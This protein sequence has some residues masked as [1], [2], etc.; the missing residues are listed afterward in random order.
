MLALDYVRSHL[1]E[2]RLATLST[3]LCL[4][5]EKR[6]QGIPTGEIVMEGEDPSGI[7]SSIQELNDPILG[8]LGI[9]IGDGNLDGVKDLPDYRYLMAWLPALLAFEY[10]LVSDC[11]VRHGAVRPL[12]AGAM[13]A[14]QAVAVICWRADRHGG[15]QRY[16]SFGV[17]GPDA[18]DIPDGR[19]IVGKVTASSPVELIRLD[20]NDDVYHQ[21]VVAAN[22]WRWCQPH[23]LVD[24]EGL[25]GVLC[26]YYSGLPKGV[27]GRNSV[28]RDTEATFLCRAT[29]T[30]ILRAESA[31]AEMSMWKRTL[32]ERANRLSV[33][34][35][36]LGLAHD[37]SARTARL[38]VVANALIDALPDQDIPEAKQQMRSQLLKMGLSPQR[39]D[40][41]ES[42]LRQV[43]ADSTFLGE[44]IEVVNK[45]SKSGTVRRGKNPLHE[46]IVGA[47]PL[48]EAI[49][50]RTCQLEYELRGR[51]VVRA[52]DNDIARLLLNLVGNAI[53]WHATKITVSTS[54][55]RTTG[56]VRLS[57]QDNGSGMSDE[58]RRNCLEPFATDRQGGTG[59]GL[60][61]VDHLSRELGGM[62]KI[63]STLGVGTTVSIDL[64]DLA[65]RK[66]TQ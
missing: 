17:A 40:S 4:K 59:L 35:I 43:E 61:V 64:P 44:T 18:V 38:A 16:A 30:G 45:L 25:V 57:V 29:L 1:E 36:V 47:R 11:S 60:F 12:L 7:D 53:Q 56:F 21:N 49:S 9:L 27:S 46:S 26:F 5:T 39:I 41:F 10:P 63:E 42:S 54:K 8:R 14:S 3:T 6:S 66:Y 15:M 33:G 22:K 58:Q 62:V 34:L 48:L 50:H 28:A 24:E 32:A 37:L 65:A 55:T 31:R 23:A 52:S 19:G 13:V 2:L 51:S 20:G